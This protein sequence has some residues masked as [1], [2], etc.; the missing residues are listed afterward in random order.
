MHQT[1]PVS[2][3]LNLHK[4]KPALVKLHISMKLLLK[5][6]LPNCTFMTDVSIFLFFVGITGEKPIGGA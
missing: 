6:F 4:G 5:L 3:T 1:L 2:D